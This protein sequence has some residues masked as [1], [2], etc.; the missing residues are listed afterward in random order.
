LQV[1]LYRP[2]MLLLVGKVKKL[3]SPLPFRIKGSAAG[4]TGPGNEAS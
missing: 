3:T 4:H 2:W 1:G